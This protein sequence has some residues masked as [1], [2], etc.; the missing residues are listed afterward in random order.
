M[1]PQNLVNLTAINI[2]ASVF[3][4]LWR[5]AI[6]ITFILYNNFYRHNKKNFKLNMNMTKYI[7]NRT[8]MTK[9]FNNNKITK[10][11]DK[12]KRCNYRQV[13]HKFHAKW[14]Q[15]QFYS[16]RC[17]NRH[18]RS[19]SISCK[20]SSN[21]EATYLDSTCILFSANT[22]EIFESTLFTRFSNSIILSYS[23][24]KKTKLNS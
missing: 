15:P 17:K 7:G 11:I 9:L 20:Q 3:N 18:N 8:F 16:Y 5:N 14:D 2:T 24:T 22:E 13:R 12:S 23:N 19:L 6:K 4:S 1:D 21:V 10:I